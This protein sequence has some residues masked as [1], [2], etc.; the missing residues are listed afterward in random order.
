MDNMKPDQQKTPQTGNTTKRRPPLRRNGTS[1][2]P[3]A[4]TTQLFLHS[5]SPTHRIVA[6]SEADGLAEVH[7]K[8][9]LALGRAWRTDW[10]EHRADA[11]DGLGR[12]TDGPGASHHDDVSRHHH[13]MSVAPTNTAGSF[14]A[15]NRI[16]R[17]RRP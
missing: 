11:R 16:R 6:P 1:T 9:A 14:A 13:R 15:T 8:E 3:D 7:E 5:Y 4:C 17:A 12:G 10:R 2:A